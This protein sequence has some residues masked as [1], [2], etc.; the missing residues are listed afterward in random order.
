MI[1]ENPVPAFLD[2]IGKASLNWLFAVG[3]LLI[4]FASAGFIFIL[5][6][7]GPSQVFP[8]FFRSIIKGL[9]DLFRISF[10]RVGAI[11]RLIIQESIRKKVI[12]VCIV[13][14]ILLMF[15]S[16]FLDPESTDPARLY[17]S[18]VLST[19]TYL[20]L[21]LALFLS[22]L[23]LPTDFKNKT[24]F[25]IV[26]KPVRASE[27]ILGRIVGL[28]LIGTVIL[29]LMAVMSY[30]FV[31]ASLTH[32][33]VVID[34]ED[35][36]PVAEAAAGTA[37]PAAVVAKGATR[38]QNWHKHDIEVYG[39]GSIIVSQVNNHT[40]PIERITEGENVRYSVGR[41]Q[42]TVQAKVPIYG[43][44]KFRDA[45]EFEKSKGIN[46]GEEWEY[47]SYIAGASPEAV[48]WSFDKINEKQFPQG[49]PIEMTISVF[50][51]HKGNIEKTIM[52]SILIRNPQNGLS[53]TTNVFNSEKYVTNAL[54]IPREIEASKVAES[55]LFLKQQ[56]EKATF[57]QQTNFPAR[58]ESYD[59]FKDF[60]VDGKVE[61]WLQCIDDG[62]YFGAA[63]PDLYVR[64]QDANVFMN[65]IKGYLGIWQQMII[66]I[67]FGVLFSTFLSGPVAMVSTFGI[68]IAAFCKQLF[69]QVAYM[70]ALGGGPVEAFS[71][72]INHDNLMT[73]MP[74]NFSTS[75]IKFFDHIASIFLSVIS[76]AVPS[77]SDY[78]IY[79]N[80]VAAGYDIPLN[81]VLVHGLT[82]LAIVV[83]LFIVAYLILRNREVAK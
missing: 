69:L 12:V 40:H 8:I 80:S 34:G 78:N 67:C 24:I 7:S 32:S 37:D 13:F 1:I 47:R 46:V 22:S 3:A 36:L 2:W 11:A 25:T 66:L 79:M 43:K 29:L 10:K 63:E 54:F 19:T 42:G 16:W 55:P 23:S 68:M 57:E 27:I 49:L 82:T 15:A 6:R 70:Q 38:L 26:T 14:L 77:F 71:R 35:V 75:L 73:E 60:V 44:M 64:A 58:K 83:P 50:R 52:G 74:K 4:V 5:V 56:G 45:N 9:E 18:F 59:L 61:I 53:A 33:H 41:E 20:V 72:L 81:T 21:L 48:I 65:F 76:L 30:V 39:D 31:S 62:Q 51:T 17:L 28:S